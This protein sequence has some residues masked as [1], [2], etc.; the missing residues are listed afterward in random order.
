M[1]LSERY[2]AI[3]SKFKQKAA[4]R[5]GGFDRQEPQVEKVFFTSARFYRGR[6]ELRRAPLVLLGTGCLSNKVAGFQWDGGS[7]WTK[8]GQGA[9][10]GDVRPTSA[11]Q[12]VPP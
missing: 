2:R 3:L 11:S 6:H 7:T 1:S 10:V 12:H 4:L 5:T 9:N 8:Q